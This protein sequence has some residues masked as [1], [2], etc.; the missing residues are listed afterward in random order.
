M[1]GSHLRLC[2]LALLLIT[3]VGVSCRAGERRESLRP[4]PAT[5]PEAPG[6]VRQVSVVQTNGGRVAWSASLDLIAFDRAQGRGPYN[7]YVMRPDGSDVQCLTCDRSGAPPG[8]KGNPAWHP[9][10][11]FIIFQAEKPGHRRLSITATPGR[12]R[13]N[14]LWLMDSGGTQFYQLT[15]VP[16]GMGVLHPHFSPDGRRLLWSERVGGGAVSDMIGEW[17]IKLADFV[18]VDGQPRLT[19]VRTYQPGGP[20][21]YETHS[22][23]PDGNVILY[24]A[25][26][27]PGQTLFGLDIYA[28]D[29][30]T[31]AVRN[32]TMTMNQWDEHAHF[33]PDG[34]HIVWMSSMGCN[35]N[36]S[37]ATDLRTDFWMMEADGSNKVRITFFNEPRHPHTT[38]SRRK[39]VAADSAW[40]PDGSRL[41]AYLIEG[42][43]QGQLVMLN[44]DRNLLRS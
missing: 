2:V 24:S 20:V 29:L 22:F 31:Q 17:A 14:D 1:N 37:R 13:N 19:N 38:V 8:H 28:M 43:D 9:S 7:V 32:L 36:P 39:I 44:L 10:G 33:S 3:V 11:Q 40:G 21:F 5:V 25:N 42:V 35:C 18:V 12:G 26:Q 34:R 30:R 27:E 4:S 16:A 23:S 41:I 6:I 15:D